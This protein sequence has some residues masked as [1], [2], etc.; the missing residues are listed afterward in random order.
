[1]LA[2][3]RTRDGLAV[4]G[5]RGGAEVRV[6][7]SGCAPGEQPGLWHDPVC[8]GED[9]AGCALLDGV[10]CYPAAMP[11]DLTE[12]ILDAFERCGPAAAWA[13]LEAACRRRW[14]SRLCVS[15]C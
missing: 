5:P 12:R 7:K 6:W 15:P 9:P 4:I 1:M 13:P 8:D 11:A 3:V 14:G 2:R 10:A